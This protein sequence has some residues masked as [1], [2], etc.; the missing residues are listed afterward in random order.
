MRESATNEK[1]AI[2]EDNH[3]FQTEHRTASSDSYTNAF[4]LA[5]LSPFDGCLLGHTLSM[6]PDSVLFHYL[7]EAH[8]W[9]ILN[10]VKLGV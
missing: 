8:C 2:Y 4:I 10:L 3:V 1:R 7:T 5:H 9:Q 6:P